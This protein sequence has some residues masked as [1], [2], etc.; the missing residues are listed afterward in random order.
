MEIAHSLLLILHFIGMAGLLGGLLA[1]SK[2]L[3]K[4]VLHSGLL[5]LVAGLG[6][7]GIRYPLVDL[8]PEIWAPID[9]AQITIKLLVLLVILS[10]G[11]KNVKKD[12]LPKNVWLVMTLLTVTNIVVAVVW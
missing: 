3:N 10:L 4:G 1:S 11:Y 2:K 12:P 7:V 9:N 6:L 8:D 5:S